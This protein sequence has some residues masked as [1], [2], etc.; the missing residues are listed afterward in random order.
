[1]T[2]HPAITG[3][4]GFHNDTIVVTNDAE[5]AAALDELSA[6]SGGTILLDGTGGPYMISAKGIGSADAPI[7]LAPVDSGRPPHVQQIDLFDASHITITGMHID[8]AAIDETREEWHHDINVRDSDTIEIID[9]TMI[10]DANGYLETADSAE[11][12][13]NGVMLR[14][15]TNI[16]FSHNSMQDYNF[17]VIYLE[18]SGLRITHNDISG[19]QGDGLRGGGIEDAVISYNHL[20]DFYGS[21][22]TVNHTDMIQIWGTNAKILTNN[23]EISHNILD[24]GAGAATQGIFIRNENVANT[25]NFQNI[26]IHDNIVHNG[27]PQGIG[28]NNVDGLSIEDNTLLWNTSATTQADAGDEFHTE[29]PRIIIRDSSEPALSG[30]VSNSITIDNVAPETGYDN[31]TL[32]YVDPNSEAYVAKHVINLSG[33][34]DIALTD[35]SFAPDSPL[36]GIYGAERSSLLQ[37]SNETIVILKPVDL[38]GN[39]LG[40]GLSAEYSLVEG[41]GVNPENAVVRWLFEDGTVREGV[42]V[43]HTFD[44]AGTQ[45]VTLEI[46]S[47]ATGSVTQTTRNVTVDSTDNLDLLITADGVSDASVWQGEITIEDPKGTAFV[48]TDRGSGFAVE[49][50]TRLVFTRENDQIYNLDTF[51]FQMMFRPDAKMPGGSLLNLHM[52]LD[53]YIQTDGSV[54]VTLYTDEGKFVIS[55][56]S[57]VLQPDTWAEIGLRYDGPANQFV[58]SVNGEVVAEGDASGTTPAET[59]H[60]L[61]IGAPFGDSAQGVVSAFS[62]DVPVSS[63]YLDD[64][65]DAAPAADVDVDPVSVPEPAPKLVP[66]L[67][68]EPAPEPEPALEPTKIW[69]PGWFRDK[70][71]ELRPRA[72]DTDRQTEDTD[73]EFLMLTGLFDTSTQQETVVPTIEEQASDEL[74]QLSISAAEFSSLD[75]VF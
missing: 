7:L 73:I 48:E 54:E 42:Y 4:S 23:V 69:Y 20:H 28:A 36:F 29:P 67:V 45:G 14:D 47:L 13:E 64:T 24:S 35:L 37:E 15:S 75:M 30:N 22:Q 70:F 41:Q 39:R 10:S 33:N 32:D 50:G 40:V 66:E 21:A 56:K 18:V 26:S 46:T 25:G 5:L 62:M 16:T 34:G 8:S 71:L 3:R 68:P 63:A 52:T 38:A 12:G 55:S 27:M 72:E 60:S 49:D 58:L 11:V 19:I 43:E 6:A 74:L 17:G 65:A 53:M 61:V 44:S 1:M 9:N 31:Y 51:D 2:T 57:G 59:Y